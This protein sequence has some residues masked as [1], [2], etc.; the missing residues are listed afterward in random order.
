MSLFGKHYQRQ[1]A[2]NDIIIGCSPVYGI[3]E[4]EIL[5]GFEQDYS[6]TYELL[7]I[8]SE[9]FHSL[10]IADTDH[11]P[12]FYIEYN[13]PLTQI[14]VKVG[15]RFQFTDSG[16]IVQEAGIF[17]FNAIIEV[18]ENVQ[19][20]F[21]PVYGNTTN[22]SSV[23]FDGIKLTSPRSRVI[24]LNPSTENEFNVFNFLASGGF[25][26]QGWPFV[27]L[28]RYNP[29][30]ETYLYWSDMGVEQWRPIYT[31]E[32]PPIPQ[33]NIYVFEGK[34][35]TYNDRVYQ[36]IQFRTFSLVVDKEPDYE[37]RFIQSLNFKGTTRDMYPKGEGDR[38]VFP[39]E[40]VLPVPQPPL[41]ETP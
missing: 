28:P 10:I 35:L 33:A 1:S 17:Q 25:A 29:L 15:S 21:K 40:S 6:A 39:P 20:T 36:L 27:L 5:R 26:P 2:Q 18:G 34:P 14:K 23:S 8:G 38:I 22:P 4:S 32:I 37:P 31:D 30:F 9:T 13:N 3:N 11:I 16:E 7:T 19:A 24:N 12:T 41:E